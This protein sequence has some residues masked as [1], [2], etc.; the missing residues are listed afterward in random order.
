MFSSSG[1]DPRGAGQLPLAVIV[2]TGLLYVPVIEGGWIG[3]DRAMITDNAAL[4]SFTGAWTHVVQGASGAI[5]RPLTVWTYG[6]VEAL[7][8]GPLG[9]HAVNMGLH[10]IAVALV[11]S[12]A[13]MLGARGRAAWLG[14][15]VFGMHPGVTEAVAWISSRG[16]LCA[17]VL[18]LAAWRALLA[19]RYPVAGVLIA[20]APFFKESW[21]VVPV[22]CLAWMWS[23]QRLGRATLALGWLGG[24][25][26]LLASHRLGLPAPLG[27]PPPD[28]IGSI[29]AGA[30][31]T[32]RLLLNPRAPDAL[33]PL[34]PSTLAGIAAFA[35]SLPLIALSRGRPYLTTY[36]AP[37]VLVVPTLSVSAPLGML[38][39]RAVYPMFCGLGIAFALGM[40]RLAVWAESRQPAVRWAPL[41]L[42]W[43]V[44]LGLA[45]FAAQR[46]G[47]WLD[48]SHV[49]G[50]SYRSNPDNPFAAFHAAEQLR[51]SNGN[52]EAALPLYEKARQVVPAAGDAMMTCLVM[53]G[54]LDEAVRLGPELLAADLTDAGPARLTA[55]ALL[56]LG[57]AADAVPFAQ[58]L[59]RRDAT[60]ATS[61]DLLGMA[62]AM[63]GDP[64]A[65]RAAYQQAAT[66]DPNDESAR[67][68]LAELPPAP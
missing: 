43:V 57:R 51:T 17:M 42:A 36:V 30:I 18:T 54:K 64:E 27:Q 22:T 63:A 33:P 26:Y 2:A 1:T 28:P 31:H 59:T 34:V 35:V 29:G 38:S 16:D 49:Y 7:H 44:P 8:G 4:A 52:C 25:I 10:L 46:A 61:W 23:T 6:L 20:L 68:G 14:A 67:E 13:M 66:L 50:A 11:A 24:G 9:E 39:D 47:A 45:A 53:A 56:R 32:V 12:L 19:G 40:E 65:A 15:A 55:W 60:T 37:L 5:Y 41:T 21:V 3:D 62:T 58:E 48:E